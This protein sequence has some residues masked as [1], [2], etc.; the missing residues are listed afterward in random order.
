MLRQ[1]GRKYRH[2]EAAGEKLYTY[3]DSWDLNGA[4]LRQLG[5]KYRDNEAAGA[6]GWLKMKIFTFG[7]AF[8][9]CV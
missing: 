1:L 3:C 5:R 9:R 2:N 8:L 7:V 4:L 6:M